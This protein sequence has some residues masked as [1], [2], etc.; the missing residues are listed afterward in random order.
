MGS[1]T[2]LALRN[3][4]RNKRRTFLT[5]LLVG[6][7]L[8]IMM[9]VDGLMLGMKDM[10]ISKVTSTWL[11]EAEIHAPQFRR[12]MDAAFSVVGA[13]EVVRRAEQVPGVEAVAPRT[14]V[15]GMISSSG[16]A[17]GG[18]IFGIDPQREQNVSR[19][20]EALTAGHMITANA[21]QDILIGYKMA[22]LLDVEIGD[23]IVL[24]ATEPLSGEI[25]QSLYFVS[26]FL[27][28]ND[29]AMD[30]STA[31]I[32]YAAGQK[33]LAMPGAAQ[34]IAISIHPSADQ[35][36]VVANLKESFAGENVELLGWWELAPDVA[37]ILAMQE[38]GLWIMAVILFILVSLGLINTMFMSIFERHYEFG[39][40][41][42]LG[43]RSSKLF[44]LICWEGALIG[45]FGA[46]L[47]LGM[48]GLANSWS[49]RYGILF[50]KGTSEFAGLTLSEPVFNQ[51]SV[52]QFTSLPAF[53]VVLT[54]L[55]C[56]I[57]AIH[58]AR[59]TPSSAMRRAI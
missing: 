33:L 51:F 22:D 55:A 50:G 28:F 17:T 5:C 6:S 3:I 37:S 48:G 57:P 34:E 24:T 42:G 58:A 21:R 39:V 16:N 14:L 4:F 29:R 7:G 8:A 49:A 59:L 19:I 54:V 2:K 9:F 53:V 47:G 25:A 20:N 10:M 35:D 13:D 52:T 40:M 31:F 41:L 23:R 11:G 45:V 27:R 12:D 43:T 30:S 38:F 44:S 1:N 15:T 18:A 56:I 46:L 36:V 26:G 32:S